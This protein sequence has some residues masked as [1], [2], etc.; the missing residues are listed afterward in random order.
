MNLGSLELAKKKKK[1]WWW[2]NEKIKACR[3]VTSISL[4]HLKT[5]DNLIIICYIV[6]RVKPVVALRQTVK[7]KEI[8]S[9]NLQYCSSSN[10]KDLQQSCLLFLYVHTV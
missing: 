1:K 9:Q 3:K 8:N 4:L 7:R 5:K 2:E 10:Q 6:Q